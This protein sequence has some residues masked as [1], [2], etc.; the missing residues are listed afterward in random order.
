M[1]AK[2]AE[3]TPSERLAEAVLVTTGPEL[4]ETVAVG[5][6]P[7]AVHHS[8]AKPAA[9]TPSKRLAEVVF[10]TT[11]PELAETVAVGGRPLAVCYSRMLRLAARRARV[12]WRRVWLASESAVAAVSA[13]T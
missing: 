10:V 7:L 11:E 8:R 2:P 1:V 3:I 4:A 9:T 6:R 12:R 13:G 5:G